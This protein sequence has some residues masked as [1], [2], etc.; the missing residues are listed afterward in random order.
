MSSVPDVSPEVVDPRGVEAAAHAA[1]PRRFGIN[2][3]ALRGI[4]GGG[5]TFDL[6]VV[7][8]HVG[9]ARG[10]ANAAGADVAVGDVNLAAIFGADRVAV[11]YE[12]AVVDV[13]QARALTDDRL[14]APLQG[15]TGDARVR[16]GSRGRGGRARLDGVTGSGFQNTA[17]RICRGRCALRHRGRPLCR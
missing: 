9:G 16:P 5:A 13:Q 14:M 12:V 6:A 3:R 17:A 11:E 15:G 10:H 4:D 1:E 2:L 7:D 8:V